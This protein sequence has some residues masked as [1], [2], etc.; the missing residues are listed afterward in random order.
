MLIVKAAGR[1]AGL[2]RDRRL[3][4]AWI[5]V[6]PSGARAQASS[7]GVWA[8]AGAAAVRQMKAA[9]ARRGIFMAGSWRE[10]AGDSYPPRPLV[11]PHQWRG[12][13][14]K[15]VLTASTTS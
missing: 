5:R 2:E 1:M 15:N 7:S 11:H 3:V 6:A 9:A 14:Q 8:P 12:D 4:Q 13:H 10:A